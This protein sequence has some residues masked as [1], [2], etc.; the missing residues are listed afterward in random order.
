MIDPRIV[1]SE[2]ERL[3]KSTLWGLVEKEYSKATLDNLRDLE[4][5]TKGEDYLRKLQG[6]ISG[7]R[8]SRRFLEVIKNRMMESLENPKG[9]S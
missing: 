3:E 7:L 5:S 2:L 4:E 8:L 6:K 1:L 9:L